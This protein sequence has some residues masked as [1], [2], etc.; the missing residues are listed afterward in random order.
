ARGP[1]PWIR[2]GLVAAMV[3]AAIAVAAHVYRGRS[4]QD[5]AGAYR[6]AQ[7]ERGDIR[8]AISATGTLA[9]ISTVD[10]GSQ[11]SGQV[12]DVLVDFNDHV[13]RGQVIARIDPSTFEAQIA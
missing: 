10:V 9:A 13:S 7:V 2:G 4:A 11:I 1:A 8:V 6:T 12:I 5:D 3:L